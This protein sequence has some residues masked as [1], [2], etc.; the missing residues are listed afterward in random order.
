MRP[1]EYFET[2]STPEPMSGC[3]LWCGAAQSKGYGLFHDDDKR[4]RSAHRGV[5]EAWKGP[6]PVGAHVL[7]SCDNPACVNPAHLFLGSNTDN[8]R[9]KVS[10]GRQSQAKGSLNGQAKLIERDVAIIRMLLDLGVKAH[11][12]ATLYNV[13]EQTISNIKANRRW[14]HVQPL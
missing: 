9:D 6:I 14:K 10:K 11:R 13:S 3:W 12:M 5:W 2:R 7:H 8:M 4:L 1:L